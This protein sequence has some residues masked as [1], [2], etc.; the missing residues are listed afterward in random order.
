MTYP[1]FYSEPASRRLIFHPRTRIEE[2]VLG[3]ALTGTPD[4]GSR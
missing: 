1:P 2:N 4:H 3:A